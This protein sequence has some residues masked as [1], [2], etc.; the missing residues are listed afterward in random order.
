MKMTEA[1]AATIA[2]VAPVIWLVAVVE[3]HQYVK[4]FESLQVLGAAA[5]RARGYAAQIEGPMTLD[6]AREMG[7]IM[8]E[9]VHHSGRNLRQ[10]PPD[11]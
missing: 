5:T 8:E 11:R 9:G 1:F 10:L 2:A 3:V 6:Q 7:R 4:R